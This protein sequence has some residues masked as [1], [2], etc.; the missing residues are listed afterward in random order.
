MGLCHFQASFPQSLSAWAISV[1]TNQSTSQTVTARRGLRAHL[2]QWF[3]KCVP[4]PAV[5]VSYG[6]VLERQIL[7][8]AELGILAYGQANCVL[9]SPPGDLD[10]GW[11]L[12]TVETEAWDEPMFLVMERTVSASL[13]A[14]SL[15]LAQCDKHLVNI[16]WMNE[17]MNDGMNDGTNDLE[18]ETKT[19]DSITPPVLLLLWG[20]MGTRAGTPSCFFLYEKGNKWSLKHYILWPGP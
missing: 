9:T 1:T 16:C 4:G 11:T 7:K 15:S 5:S 17:W 6:N 12:R 19:L 20:R 14:H 10:V 8:P 3:S 13:T 18:Q 2:I